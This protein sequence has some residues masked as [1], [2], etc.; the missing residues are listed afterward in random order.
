MT[1]VQVASGQV[2]DNIWFIKGENGEMS[3]HTSKQTGNIGTISKARW[4]II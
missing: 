3:K 1:R 4:E 2:T